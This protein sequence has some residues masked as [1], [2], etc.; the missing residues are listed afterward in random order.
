MASV[1]LDVI[2]NLQKKLSMVERL[3]VVLLE[4]SFKSSP[5]VVVTIHLTCVQLLRQLL[6]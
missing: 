2:P 4:D 3:L 6:Q 1:S 5:L